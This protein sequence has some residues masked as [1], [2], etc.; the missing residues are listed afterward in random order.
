MSVCLAELLG[1]E[2][3][4]DGYESLA[5]DELQ[6]MDDSEGIR[7]S[8][9]PADVRRVLGIRQML[10]SAS[11][12]KLAR[13]R[14]C[15][16]ADGRGR[17]YGG[18][19]AMTARHYVLRLVRGG[20]LVPARLQ[21]I[22]TEPNEPDNHRDRWPALLQ[23]VDVAGEVV[24]P[25]ELTER[26]HWAPGHWKSLTPISRAEYDHRLAMMR[27]AERNSPDDP[28][29]KARRRV[30]REK[31]PLPRFDRENANVG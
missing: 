4:G 25:E 24:P 16:G 7:S 26:F 17:G 12:K 3:E 11:I 27:W 15:T 13:M 18:G 30:D 22:N 23:V 2:E 31:M 8:E 28:R 29:L 6:D 5:G 14:A 21:E 10:G 19:G 9:L 1:D 20:P